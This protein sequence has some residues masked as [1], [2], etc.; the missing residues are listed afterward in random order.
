M[1]RDKELTEEIIE[2]SKLVGI[3]IIGF[4]DPSLFNRFPE[5]NQ[6]NSIIKNTNTVIIIGIHLYDIILDAWSKSEEIGKNVQFADSILQNYC[7]SIRRLLIKRGYEAKIITYNPGLYL[8]DAAALAGMGPIGKN[9]MLITKEYGSQVRLRAIATSAPLNVGKPIFE[10]EYCEDCNICIDSCPAE[11]FSTGKYEKE[12]C[13]KYNY[14]NWEVLSDYSV[15]WC[16]ICIESC[17]IGKK[18]DKN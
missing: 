4:A 17:P 12:P 6:P 18:R 13:L 15:I 1:E 5:K 3:D 9:N 10:S 2:Y 7:H 11:A 14:A 8:K 16:N